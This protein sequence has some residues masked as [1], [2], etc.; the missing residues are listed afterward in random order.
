MI[1][2]LPSAESAVKFRNA[3]VSTGG[4]CSII[5]DNTWHFAKHWKALEAMGETDWFGTR[6]PSYAPASLAQSDGLLARTVM[7]GLNIMMDDSAVEAIIHAI[8]AGA[9][10]A[11]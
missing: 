5:A 7:F 9:K 1:F 8:R 2:M 10:A 11:L 6:T 4:G 3:A